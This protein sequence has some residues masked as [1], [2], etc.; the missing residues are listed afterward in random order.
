MP[1]YVFA[2]Q[3][4]KLKTYSIKVHQDNPDFNTTGRTIINK[5]KNMDHYKKTKDDNYKLYNNADTKQELIFTQFGTSKKLNTP[6]SI[7]KMI[8]NIIDKIKDDS[9]VNFL[10]KLKKNKSKINMEYINSVNALIRLKDYN[11]LRNVAKTKEEIANKQQTIR[12]EKKGITDIQK[13]RVE[14]IIQKLLNDKEKPRMMTNIM[15]ELIKEDENNRIIM[16]RM[17]DSKQMKSI[18][19]KLT[20]MKK[21]AEKQNK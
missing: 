7:K 2:I 3:N 8:Y 14:K 16:N 18:R 1:F 12:D 9:I 4:P 21:D 11:L 13:D 6:I 5:F 17:L 20:R 19:N 10:E 15:I